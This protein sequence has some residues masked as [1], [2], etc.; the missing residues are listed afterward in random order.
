MFQGYLADFAIF[1]RALSPEEVKA[2]YDSPNGIEVN[3]PSSCSCCEEMRSEM[4]TILS[5]ILDLVK[6]PPEPVCNDKKGC[7][8]LVIAKK[9]LIGVRLLR[10]ERLRLRRKNGATR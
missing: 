1:N 9:G 5:E 2:I 3:P 10:N 7:L 8:N 4:N 6:T